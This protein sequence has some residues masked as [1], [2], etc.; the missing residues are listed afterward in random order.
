MHIVQ[1]KI[2]DK[3]TYADT[4]RYSELRPEK[5]ES[6]L[7]AYHLKCLIKD[8]YIEKQDSNYTLSS[9]GKSYVDKISHRSLKV[10]WQPKIITILDI[11][12]DKGETLLFRRKHQPYIEMLAFPTG[13][14]HMFETVEEASMREI[15][16]KLEF[17]PFKIEHRGIV[18][19]TV[20]ENGVDITQVLAHVFHGRTN[21]DFAA[22]D[23]FRAA[24]FWADPHQFDDKEYLPG[25][26]EIKEL[27]KSPD[28]FFDE[29][30]FD[31]ADYS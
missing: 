24:R 30:K 1:S 15:S 22:D 8:G 7:F 4:L 11:V 31:L 12:N 16:E 21:Q 13:K 6:N 3:L 14:L 20:A 18:Y 17:E 23:T 19:V 25:F 9:M 5:T 27:L 10:R 2:L 26:W 29:L 28:F